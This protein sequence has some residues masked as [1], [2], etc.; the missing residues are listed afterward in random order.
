MTSLLTLD[1]RSFA[2]GIAILC[3][4][5][6]LFATIRD[7]YGDPPHWTRPPGLATLVR[8]ICEQSVSLASAAAV[9]Q[10]LST[11]SNELALNTLAE[12]SVD[13]LRSTGLSRAK[14]R[15]IHELAVA[16]QQGTFDL[17]ALTHATDDAVRAQLTARWGIGPW[18]AES[19]LLLALRRADAWPRGDIALKRAVQ[20]RCE[21]AAAPS[22]AVLDSMA[23]DWRPWRG[24]AAHLLWHDHLSRRGL[25]WAM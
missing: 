2:D 22:S 18:T 19:Y 17:D 15:T 13:A 21:M 20:H 9:Y 4:D 14:A 12:L 11:L 8:T 6:P 16:M 7:A 25:V 10:R 5:V 3:A 24:V 1:S 23:Q